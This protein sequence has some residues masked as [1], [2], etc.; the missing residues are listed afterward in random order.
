MAP[1]PR[2]S[3]PLRPLRVLLTLT[4]FGNVVTLLLAVIDWISG[5][6]IRTEFLAPPEALNNLLPDPL[7]PAF[8]SK[9]DDLVVVTIAEPT[10][11]QRMLEVVAGGA[12]GAVAW[13][14]IAVLARRIVDSA[15]RADPFTVS[16]AV[17]LRRLGVIILAAGGLAEVIGMA[18]AYALYRSVFSD[19]AYTGPILGFWW[20]PLGLAVLAFAA[21]VR[22]GC[23]LR[24]E[25]DEVI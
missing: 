22:H 12:V 14:V 1:T 8:T 17:Q 21:V 18:A 6:R 19:S 3:G 24:T 5:G 10:L 23:A 4:I 15:L 16:T 20:L 25:L 11:V 9:L 2:R 13:L 7:Q